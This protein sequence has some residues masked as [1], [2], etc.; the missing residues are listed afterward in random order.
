MIDA[1]PEVITR[2][3]FE[4][5]CI[6]LHAVGCLCCALNAALGF[7]RTNLPVEIHHLN[8]GGLHGGKRRGDRYT[9]PLCTWHHQGK[10]FAGTLWS[11]A[12]VYGPSWKGGSKPF[13]RVYGTDDE[14]LAMADE[15]G[16]LTVALAIGTV[17]GRVLDLVTA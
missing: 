14:L 3:E 2:A 1:E 12:L 7:Q 16:S 11:L 6:A 15:R 8:E 13:R 10:G 5:R 9:I 17:R 4:L